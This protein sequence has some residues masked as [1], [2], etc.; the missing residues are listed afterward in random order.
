[1]R[2]LN[3]IVLT[4]RV[5]C[6]WCY[7]S[8]T[9]K[10][11]SSDAVP[12]G[13]EEASDLLVYSCHWHIPALQSMSLIKSH[14]L[15][16]ADEST[17]YFVG[18]DEAF[19]DLSLHDSENGVPYEQGTIP[20]RITTLKA[21][22]I[23]LSISPCLLIPNHLHSFWLVDNCPFQLRRK[24]N[25]VVTSQCRWVFTSCIFSEYW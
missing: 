1:M 14:T 23:S 13:K 20:A 21:S 25:P 18:T 3:Y 2:A 7:H 19:R 8:S 15:H 11:H 5:R 16:G 22:Q 17:H 12:G 6:F 4:D 24:R 9:G 10:E